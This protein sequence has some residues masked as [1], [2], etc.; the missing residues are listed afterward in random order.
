M[1]E[2]LQK[3]DGGDHSGG[4]RQYERLEGSLTDG[5]S[6]PGREDSDEGRSFGA[7]KRP[8]PDEGAGHEDAGDPQTSESSNEG[9]TEEAAAKP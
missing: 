8:G 2:D 3:K 7:G 5:G 6:I 4:G 9:A 1:S